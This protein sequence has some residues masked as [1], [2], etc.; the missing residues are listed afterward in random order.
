M[1]KAHIKLGSGAVVDVEGTPAEITELLRYFDSGKPSNKIEGG[2]QPGAPKLIRGAPKLDREGAPDIASIVNLTKECKEAEAIE[3]QV[4]DAP[5]RIPRVL[6]PLYVVCAYQEN[7]AGLTSG[8]I[9][10]VTRELGA[11]VN[12]PNVSTVLATSAARYVV[13]DKVR[14]FGRP[15]RYKLSRRGLLY[16]RS[17]LGKSS[18]EDKS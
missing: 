7:N 14:V 3:T 4:L 10:Q 18:G 5:G 16:F 2:A 1:A 8:E 17:L 9:A 11:P 15:V 6:L 12:Q 13:G